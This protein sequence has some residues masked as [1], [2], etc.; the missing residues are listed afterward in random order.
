MA[1]DILNGFRILDLS[2]YIPGPYAGQILA[3][4]GAE[5]IKVEAPA[6]DPMRKIGP[7]DSDGVSAFYK[8]INAGKTVTVVDLK[9]EGGKAALTRLVALA[10]VMVES[11][12]PGVLGRLGFGSAALKSINPALIHVA[13][14]GF[15]QSGPYANRAGHDI[16]YMALGGGLA[17]SGTQERPVIAFPPTADFAGGMQTALAAIAAL[18]RRL[19]TGQG[20][21][22]DV[23]LAET[24]LAWQGLSLTAAS[25]PGYQPQRGAGLL[26]GGAACYQIYQ[27]ADAR[28]ITLGALEEK[29]WANFC[30]AIGQHDWIERQWE[31]LPQDALIA[32]VTAFIGACSLAHLENVLA[33]VDCCFQPVLDLNQVAENPQFKA[34]GMVHQS[35]VADGL[36]ETL[37]PA[38]VDSQR[39]QSRPPIRTM[40]AADVLSDWN[41]G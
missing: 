3:D 32:E 36:A 14:S 4:L 18:L 27:T 35:G 22:I 21:S 13:L 37:F 30:N 40:T 24:V 31:P 2:Q 16:N 41:S 5:V 20:A 6:G 1:L 7:L 39:P 23:S 33:N 17:G 15:G 28:F 34:R 19:R 12:R 10:D 9:S 26:S 8:Q 25:R 29:F 38:I 11:F